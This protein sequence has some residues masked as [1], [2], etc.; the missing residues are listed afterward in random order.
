MAQTLTDEEERIIDR[1]IDKIGVKI[2]ETQPSRETKGAWSE[3]Y[4]VEGEYYERCYG[5]SQ[6]AWMAFI[7]KLDNKEEL[8]KYDPDLDLSLVK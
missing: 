8:L 6:D 2:L 3:V 1:K 4:L 5:D 7:M